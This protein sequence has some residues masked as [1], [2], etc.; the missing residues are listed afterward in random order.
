MIKKLTIE[1]FKSIRHLEMECSNIN[2]LIGVNSSG[3]SSIIQGLL[4][5]AQNID[6]SCGLNGAFISVG[7]FEENRC[8]YA[9]KKEISVVVE[10]E[11]AE[12]VTMGLQPAGD[13]LKLNRDWCSQEGSSGL[14]AVLSI[15]ERKI[16]YLS[17][18][19][20]VPQNVYKKSVQ[21]EEQIGN[22]GEYAIAYLNKHGSDTLDLSLCRGTVD[23]TLLGQVN[24][25]L[26]YIVDTE[27]STEEISGADLV[28]ASYS[29]NDAQNMRPVNIGSGI[30]YLVS[31][32]IMCLASP[33]NAILVI[34]NPEIH[35]HPSAQAKVCEFLYLIASTGRQLFVESHSDHIFNGFRAGIA[36]GDMECERINM[37]F[38]RLNEE[39]VTETMRVEVGRMGRIENQQKD[40]FD[41]FDLDMNRMIGIRG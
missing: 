11:N 24:W 16:Q 1:N 2:L 29:M 37:Q 28:R 15:R 21:L 23:Y 33:E 6:E 30:S 19:R 38:V 35:L 36:T 40:L 7:S 27:I 39:H 31:V 3:K 41:Q 4:F 22:D 26:T 17:C 20:V 18:H 13:V 12:S 32:L 9:D 10:N 34:E 8:I 14:N 5:V 25:W